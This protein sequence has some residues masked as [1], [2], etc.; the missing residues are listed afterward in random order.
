MLTMSPLSKPA[1]QLLTSSYI[2]DSYFFKNKKKTNN[3][4]GCCSDASRGC[5]R[6]RGSACNESSGGYID[7]RGRRY[8]RRAA[9]CCAHRLR[10]GA[11]STSGC[12]GGNGRLPVT[13]RKVSASGNRAYNAVDAA[14]VL[15]LIEV[16]AALV[17]AAVV[18]T[19]P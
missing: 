7:S 12:S 18:D 3:T 5:R 11:S 9:G 10:Q 17:D 15:A 13:A 8:H 2:S 19:A 16:L 1:R 14:A 4:C 6:N